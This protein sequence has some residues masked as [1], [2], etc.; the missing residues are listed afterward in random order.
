VED[1]SA[2]VPATEKARQEQARSVPS[3]DRGTARERVAP[4]VHREAPVN[5]V[6]KPRKL[7]EEER[8]QEAN[9]LGLLLKNRY[10]CRVWAKVSPGYD[11]SRAGSR[12]VYLRC[13]ARWS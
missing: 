7:D 13:H 4:E 3:G 10:I 12:N 8:D 5:G 2:A 1:L 11:D 6:W 9:D